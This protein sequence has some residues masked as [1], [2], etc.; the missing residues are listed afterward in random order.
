[1]RK[2]K[3]EK[4]LNLCL[5]LHL[6]PSGG[7]EIVKGNNREGL[8]LLEG[9]YEGG[10][11]WELDGASSSGHTPAPT[12]YSGIMCLREEMRARNQ[13]SCHCNTRTQVT[14]LWEVH[15]EGKLFPGLILWKSR[16]TSSPEFPGRGLE[17]VEIQAFMWL[18]SI[19][20]LRYGNT[21]LICLVSPIF[22]VKK[23]NERSCDLI[24]H[25]DLILME[26]VG[27]REHEVLWSLW[28]SLLPPGLRASSD[29]D[30]RVP[31]L[32]TLHKIYSDVLY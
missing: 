10:R 32:H 22:W 3:L 14:L 6:L 15:T 28:S 11:S 24:L 2:D 7:E 9:I 5:H 4:K 26:P 17:N 1:M 13:K 20:K 19:L 8:G 27:P 29:Q 21:S 23:K 30:L 25:N 31:R 12:V 18:C 16:L